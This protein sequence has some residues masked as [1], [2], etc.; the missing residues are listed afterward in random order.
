ML[1][2]T[3][4]LE[5]ILANRTNTKTNSKP[6]T[7]ELHLSNLRVVVMIVCI[8]FVEVK[9]F[10]LTKSVPRVIAYDMEE[11]CTYSIREL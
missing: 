11:V 3:S 5:D 4:H 1:Q 6:P 2:F 8:I 7:G 9:P 10:E